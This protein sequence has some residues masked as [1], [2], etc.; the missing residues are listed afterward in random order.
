M[1]IIISTMVCIGLCDDD[2][3]ND[4]DDN[5]DVMCCDVM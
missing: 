1:N 3:D 2:D 4:D 5:D